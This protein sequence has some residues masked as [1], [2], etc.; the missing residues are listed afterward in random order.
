MK[1]LKELYVC[2]NELTDIRGLEALPALWRVSVRNNKLKNI[3]NPFPTLPALTYLNLRENQIAKIEDVKKI[4]QHVTGINLLAN[5]VTDELGEGF[6]R[7]IV[8]GLPWI[9]RLNKQDVTV[10][11][12]VTFEKEMIEKEKERLAAEEEARKAAEEKEAEG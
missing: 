12:R 5:P 4:D 10:E 11:E 9:C 7:D 6:R 2:E 1:S 8:T 3:Y